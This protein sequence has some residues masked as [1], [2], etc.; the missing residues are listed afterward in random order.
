MVGDGAQ[1]RARRGES[2]GGWRRGPGP[3]L[4]QLLLAGTCGRMGG[5]W[6]RGH[7]SPTFRPGLSCPTSPSGL[8]AGTGPA[9]VSEAAGPPWVQGV[10]RRD[11]QEPSCSSRREICSLRESMRSSCWRE[12]AR[13]LPGS[14]SPCSR[15]RDAR[16]CSGASTSCSFCRAG[17]GPGWGQACATLDQ[18]LTLWS[19]RT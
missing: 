12:W 4:S 10:G 2:L 16:L 18:P 11:S 19:T 7:S 1:G 14:G 5:G 8:W 13:R 15:A 6:V 9:S 17:R 3:G